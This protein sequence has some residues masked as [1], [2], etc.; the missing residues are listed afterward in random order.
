VCA[1][2]RASLNALS[3]SLIFAPS[4]TPLAIA[5]RACVSK[6]SA[7][8]ISFASNSASLVDRT[9]SGEFLVI[10]SAY[11]SA[12]GRRSLRSGTTLFTLRVCTLKVNAKEKANRHSQAEPFVCFSGRDRI[13][14]E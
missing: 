9:A 8:P 13:T 12:A 6:L 1:C 5:E 7:M 4:C 3:P 11:F 14:S 10:S 2:V